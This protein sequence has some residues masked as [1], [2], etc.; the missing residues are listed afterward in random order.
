MK[1]STVEVEIVIGKNCKTKTSHMCD[2]ICISKIY[3]CIHAYTYLPDIVMALFCYV[4][5]ESLQWVFSPLKVTNS[6]SIAK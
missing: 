6:K 2:P 5:F 1:I 3:V 4:K